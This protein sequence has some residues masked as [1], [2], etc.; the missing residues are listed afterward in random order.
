MPDTPIDDTL[1]FATL[2]PEPGAATGPT[3]HPITLINGQPWEMAWWHTS[4]LRCLARAVPSGS[5]H[6]TETRTGKFGIELSRL[7]FD[8]VGVR[9][10][11]QMFDT[12][13]AAAA[14]A[15]SFAWQTR[16]HAGLTWYA[17]DTDSREWV[18]VLSET[19]HAV[20]NH[21]DNDTYAMKRVLTPRDGESYEIS[22]NR[23]RVADVDPSVRTFAEAA[24]IALTLPTFVGML[25]GAWPTNQSR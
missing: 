15:E 24:A 14:A 2:K 20:V 13:A 19:D 7:E 1:T 21:Y 22:A 11:G 18:A 9:H 16:E 17:I 25:G 4:S 3:G 10:R 8:W 6:I 12:L 5:A 23:Y